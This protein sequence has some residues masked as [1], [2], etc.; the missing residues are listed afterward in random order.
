MHVRPVIFGFAILLGAMAPNPA[1]AMERQA[2]DLTGGCRVRDQDPGTRK[3]FRWAGKCQDGFAQGSG[4]LE[5]TING[6]LAGWAE[7]TLVAGQLEGEA[8]IEWE[9]GRSFTG[10]YRHGLAS[11][12]GTL[13]FPGG[14]RY[15]G[16]F[17]GGRPT[18][19]GEFISSA[20]TRYAAR[21]DEDG[22]VQ[23]GVMLGLGEAAP[24]LSAGW[25]LPPEPGKDPSPAKPGPRHKAPRPGRSSERSLVKPAE[26][27]MPRTAEPG[28]PPQ[29][30]DAVQ[31]AERP[32]VAAAPPP[33]SLEEWLCPPP[34]VPRSATDLRPAG[35][36]RTDWSGRC[37]GSCLR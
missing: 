24:A 25:P 5:W 7:G 12:R 10:T 16:S 27:P 6:R 32:P 28:L 29:A 37:C 2:S 35:A 4:V 11:G 36:A 14:H 9:D 23:P 21:L 30:P 20:G 26:K 13:T 34:P 22:E 8:H 15:V 31:S 33:E 19:E 3:R 1:L 17:E 18:G